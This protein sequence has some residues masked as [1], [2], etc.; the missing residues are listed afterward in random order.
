MR[1]ILFEGFYFGKIWKN[2]EKRP[3]FRAATAGLGIYHTGGYGRIGVYRVK[4]LSLYNHLEPYV[5]IRG[6]QNGG[7]GHVKF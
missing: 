1:L 4:Q 7:G 5:T 6:V 3:F 2:M